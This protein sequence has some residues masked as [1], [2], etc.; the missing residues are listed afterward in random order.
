MKL[1]TGL[2]LILIS[3][4][5]MGQSYKGIYVDGFKRILNDTSAQ[6]S[7][8]NYAQQHAVTT[9]TLYELFQV[10]QQHDLTQSASAQ[11]LANFIY[12][13]KTQYGIQEISATGENYWFFNTVI[14]PYNSTH[15]LWEE[16]IDV[17]NLEFEFWNTNPAIRDYYSNTY[18]IP[19]GFSPNTSGAYSFYL[20]Q[21]QQIK[22][23]AANDNVLTETY[24]GWIDSV[25]V[26]GILASADRVLLHAYVNKPSKAFS[27]AKAR[28]EV[29]GNTLYKANIIVLFSAETNFLGPYLNSNGMDAVY[30]N[31]TDSYEQAN[32][33]WKKSV[34][35][36]GQQWF[37]YSHLPYSGLLKP[38][39]AS[40]AVIPAGYTIG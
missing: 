28:L 16:R 31:F 20:T 9:L 7:L 4:V 17:Y 24:I 3:Y 13:A 2:C 21:L 38:L 25:P 34:S 12:K 27:Y 40:T 36:L 30:Q 6:D 22:Q 39:P 23:Q 33:N 5:A 11:I 37:A 32:G 15:T 18:L 19:N 35:L 10:H 8:L 14:A 26:A 1:L 29:L